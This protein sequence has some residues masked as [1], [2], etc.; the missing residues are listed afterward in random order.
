L[1]RD[2]ESRGKRLD[3]V[4]GGSNAG[5]QGGATFASDDLGGADCVRLAYSGKLMPHRQ[6]EL[7]RNTDWVFSTR[8]IARGPLVLPL[9]RNDVQLSDLDIQA[10]DGRYDLIDYISRNR[11]AALLILKQ[12]HIALERYELGND[13]D[14]RWISMSMAKSIATTLVGA[15]IQDGY[16]ASVDEPL[17]RY[18]P[19]LAGGGYEGVSIR[20]LLQ[21]TSGVRWDDT[22]TDPSSERRQ[23]LEMQI[24]QQPGV[25][26]R[27]MAN[28]PRI[29]APG[30]VWNYSTGETH[31]VGALLR[32]AVGRW[33]ADYLSEKIWSK[34][35]M[36]SDATWWLEAPHGLEVAG[37]GVNATLRDYA[38]F[39]LFLL[40]DGVVGNE[41]VLPEGWMREATAPRQIGGKQ[42]DYGYMWWPVP[43]SDGSFDDGAFSAR[44]IFGQY[45]YVNPR[46]QVVIVVL[47]ARA[48]PKG[49]EAILDNDFFNS[50]V[51]ALKR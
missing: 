16:I 27:Y 41:R 33:I 30:T 50:A 15:A 24:A 39:G 2:G 9:P 31:V 29:A 37:S 13:A 5:A 14:T 45:I 36:Q 11:V 35:G 49:S 1:H 23:M 3:V 48:K 38:R 32:A 42:L 28:L 47:S 26:L 40:N 51:E 20:H 4:V 7:F 22:H 19:E 10:K 25:I 6:L 21:M 43:A 17:T 34:V 12:G 18:L 44:G 8:T 46:E